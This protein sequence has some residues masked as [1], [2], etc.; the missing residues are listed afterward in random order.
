MRVAATVLF[1]ALLHFTATANAAPLKAGAAA[2]D[3]T[4]EK[5]PVIVN[6]SFTEKSANSAQD[7]LHARAIVLDDGSTRLAIVV[8]DSCMMPREFLDAAKELIAAETKI[9]T[10]RQLISATHTHTAPSVAGVLGSGVDP[11][12]G[13]FLQRQLVQAVRQANAALQPAEV[14][15]A[16]ADAG[17]LTNNRQW[18]LRADKTQADPF[19]KLTVRSNMHPGYQNPDFVGPSGPT[20]PWLSLVSVR[21]RDG[22]P[23]ALLANFSMH[24]F[25]TPPLS[26]DYFGLFCSKLEE[27]TKTPG[28][29]AMMSQGTS[30]DLQWRDYAAAQS[31]VTMDGY[32]TAMADIAEKALKGIPYRSDLTLA[33]AETKLTLPRR[34]PD[35]ERL[36]WAKGV[37]EKMQVRKPATKPE[38]YAREAVLIQEEPQRELK[39]QAVRIGE[40]GIAA[41]PDEVFALTGLKIKAYSP[42]PATFTM[43]LANGC[44]GYIPPP[45]QHPLGGYTT[46]PARTAGLEEQAEPKILDAVLKLLEKVAGKPRRPEINPADDPYAKLVLSSKPVA[47]WRLGE[48]AGTNAV[49]LVGKHDGKLETGV[50]HALP[51][52]VAKQFE[53]QTLVNRASHFAGGRVIAE[54][55]KLGDKY[56]VECWLWNGVPGDARE[57]LGVPFSLG[58][59][60]SVRDSVTIVKNPLD[61]GRVGGKAKLPARFPHFGTSLSIPFRSWDH[62][63]L[64]RDRRELTLYHDGV[65][66]LHSTGPGGIEVEPKWLFVGGTPGRKDG[67]EGRIAEVAV[68]D[69]VLTPQDAAARIQAARGK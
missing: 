54:L 44:D 45:E 24:Y 67:F 51:G 39:L 1:A 10:D 22:K 20:D 60:E 27:R 69:R 11:H 25:G 40:I 4:P 29:V 26:A 38:V 68:Y 55:P 7:R 47:Y 56:S 35:A 33:M 23:L 9:P 61:E 62:L 8:V 42:L 41:I 28:F 37:I 49:D 21:T 50:V 17:K 5:F 46:W 3:I 66:V 65:Q 64:V 13:E 57:I 12:Y 31:T 48:A 52:P 53:G 58:T 2:V 34:L 32:A 14:G 18:V 15:W 43:E 36:A 6:G 19:G 63:L 30:G 16:V 59:K